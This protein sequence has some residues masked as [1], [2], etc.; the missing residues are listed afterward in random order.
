MTQ[1][2]TRETFY[3]DVITLTRKVRTLFDARVSSRGLTYA[4][5]RL[6]LHMS[7][8]EVQ[9]QAKLAEAMEVERPTMARLIDGLEDAGLVRREVSP[10]DRRQRYVHLTE[11]AKAQAQTVNALTEAMRGELVEGISDADLDT[12]HRV[13][14]QM[15]ENIARSANA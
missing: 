2:E 10:T 13:I 4:R 7:T 3:R 11:P 14:R 9:S 1:A 5:A 15:M 12:A 8:S 6:L